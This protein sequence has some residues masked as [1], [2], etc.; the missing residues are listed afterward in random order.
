MKGETRA[1]VIL[2]TVYHFTPVIFEGIIHYMSLDAISVTKL[3][4]GDGVTHAKPYINKPRWIH[5][6]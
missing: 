3:G 1:F 2:E 4:P 5:S 6:C